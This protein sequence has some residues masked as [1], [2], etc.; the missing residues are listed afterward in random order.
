MVEKCG[1][2]SAKLCTLQCTFCGQ[3]TKYKQI[4]EVQELPAFHKSRIKPR[5]AR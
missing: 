5:E 2:V 4:S 1:I 3:K